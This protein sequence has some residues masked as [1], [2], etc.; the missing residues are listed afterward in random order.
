MLH[1]RRTLLLIAMLLAAG[2]L[3]CTIELGGGE[4]SKPMV[5]VLSPPNGSRVE[6]GEEVE[7]QYQAT[8]AVAVVSVELEVD[9]RTVAIDRSSVTEGMPSLTGILRWTGTTPGTHTLLL[10]AR[11]RDGAVSDPVGVSIIVEQ[12]P[13]TSVPPTPT[14][15]P[16]TP[17][18]TH[19]LPPPTP[20]PPTP[21]ETQVAP[22]PAPPTPT[23][24]AVPPTAVPPTPT[25]TSISCPVISI[26]A[27]STAWPSRN[28]TLEWDSSPHA[29]PPG[30]EWGI[31]YKGAEDAWTEET[32]HYQV[33]LVSTVGSTRTFECCGPVPAWPIIHTR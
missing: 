28:F 15:T 14:Q 21:T 3:A 7:V 29:L 32:L 11:S 5:E 23:E 2:M 26:N 10:Y 1:Y 16:A 25:S 13:A 27:P 4:V 9:G 20:A 6:V 24:T 18:A 17:T 8:D 22:T 30:W 33:C 12:P 31:R 19:T